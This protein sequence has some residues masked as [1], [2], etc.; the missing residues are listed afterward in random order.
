[1]QPRHRIASRAVFVM[2]D[3]F[4]LSTR[5]LLAATCHLSLATRNLPP[6]ALH[7]DARPSTCDPPAITSH[8]PRSTSHPHLPHAT[9]YPSPSSRNAPLHTSPRSFALIRPPASSRNPPL[10]TS[11]RCFAL[12]SPPALQPQ[13]ATYHRP[14]GAAPK[15]ALPCATN[16]LRS[17]LLSGPPQRIHLSWQ[18]RRQSL[19]PSLEQAPPESSCNPHARIDAHQRF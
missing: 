8:L 19:Q 14:Q 16:R 3:F 17:L 4:V 11:P 15:P 18:Y 13:P 7:L 5:H 1:M 12:I 6:A 2:S 10:H 9:F